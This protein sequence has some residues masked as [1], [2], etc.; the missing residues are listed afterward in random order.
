VYGFTNGIGYR[1]VFKN[2][3]GHK[4]EKSCPNNRLEWRKY[5]GRNYRGNRIGRIVKAVDIIKY[6]GQYYN[7][8]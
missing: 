6:Q 7:N 8:Y 5:L 1:V 4:V 2:K 3:E